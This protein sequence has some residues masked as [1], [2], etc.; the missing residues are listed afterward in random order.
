METREQIRQ[1]LEERISGSE[2]FLVD[3]KVSPGK[4]AVMVD[5]PSGITLEECSELNRFLQDLLEP[6]GLLE[7][8]ELEVGSPG[9]DS[10]LK[11]PQ[12]YLRR[13]GRE[14]SILDHS[15]RPMNG[16]LEDADQSGI[17][18]R[19]RKVFRQKGQKPRVEETLLRIPYSEI[20]E[21]RLIIKIK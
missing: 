18:F 10:P 4:V 2:L 8:H 15:G 3:V 12:Q 1:A 9:M 7:T 13:I 20:K 6:Q 5:K 16:V 21:A 17:H 14:F 11:V 19:E